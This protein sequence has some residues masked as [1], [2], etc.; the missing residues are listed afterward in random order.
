M[1]IFCTKHKTRKGEFDPNSSDG[2]SLLSV[3][4]QWLRGNQVPF[5]QCCIDHDQAFWY[6]GSKEVHRE[7]DRK[8]RE[9]IKQ[10][11]YP[12]TAW[13]LWAIVRIFGSP[14]S[15]FPQFR[16]PENVTIVKDQEQNDTLK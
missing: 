9:C 1:G 11:G 8:F 5:R 13:I 7:A 12:V 14:C 15:P 3:V 16:W 6:G 10:S 4:W 2:C